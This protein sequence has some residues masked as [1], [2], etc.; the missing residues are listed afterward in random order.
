MLPAEQ[1]AV[2]AWREGC[3]STHEFVFPSSLFPLP[4]AVVYRALL[5]SDIWRVSILP[6]VCEKERWL[7]RHAV[8]NNEE[9]EFQL[10]TLP[11]APT[12][13]SELAQLSLMNA[14]RAS[15][16]SAPEA[17][18]REW[19][20]QLLAWCADKQA[21]AHITHT[22][23]ALFQPVRTDHFAVVRADTEDVL[24]E[25]TRVCFPGYAMPFT[26][27]DAAVRFPPLTY[28]RPAAPAELG[29]RARFMV[30]RARDNA[31]FHVT[32]N[33]FWRRE[34]D[35]A[36]GAEHIRFLIQPYAPI[37]SC[38]FLW[39]STSAVLLMRIQ[40]ILEGFEQRR[41]GFAFGVSTAIVPEPVF[42]EAE[43]AFEWVLR[44]GELA[45][46]WERDFE[47]ARRE[48]FTST[49]GLPLAME[50]R[51]VSSGCVDFNIAAFLCDTGLQTLYPKT[52]SRLTCNINPEDEHAVITMQ[53]A[54]GADAAAAV[55]TAADADRVFLH[56]A[57]LAA[58][59]VGVFAEKACCNHQQRR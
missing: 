47:R 41:E 48:T 30:T 44:A 15:L 55:P 19:H 39:F 24:V 49:G 37:Y 8:S 13:L 46:P 6:F 21:F 54:S 4:M 57:Q 3:A 27:S 59:A 14:H 5:M 33:V 7:N 22:H 20:T 28:L 26:G 56:V 11:V 36:A 32:S 35:D 10:Q 40:Y 51:E 29:V 50:K 25:D 1:R 42:A 18:V 38:A 23:P 53:F 58:R 17:F 9:L 31:C 2:V 52:L 43:P 12:A 34:R 45:L 16:V